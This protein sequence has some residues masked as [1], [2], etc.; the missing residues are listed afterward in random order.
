MEIKKIITQIW[1]SAKI[2]RYTEEKEKEYRKK[3]FLIDYIDD[4][5]NK[6]IIMYVNKD[7][8][9]YTRIQARRLLEKYKQLR[10]EL[11]LKIAF[12]WIIILSIF[13][14]YIMSKINNT[15]QQVNKVVNSINQKIDKVDKEK[16]KVDN[17][18]EKAKNR[19]IEDY[20]FKN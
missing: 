1:G 18:E 5:Q 3:N 19:T 16:T 20:N 2:E 10:I 15:H 7:L 9:D 8:N 17:Q 11:W 12:W 14:V 13:T 4:Y 6:E